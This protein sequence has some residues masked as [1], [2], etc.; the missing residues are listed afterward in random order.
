MGRFE[1]WI[2]LKQKGHNAE[3]TENHPL[4][5]E[6]ALVGT[7]HAGSRRERAFEFT[8]NFRPHRALGYGGPRQKANRSDEWKIQVPNQVTSHLF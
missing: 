6:F 2:L 1:S 4:G 7:E 3:S 5:N 8:Y